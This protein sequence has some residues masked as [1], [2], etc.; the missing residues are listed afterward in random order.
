MHSSGTVG[1]GLAPVSASDNSE[2]FISHGKSKKNASALCQRLELSKEQTA[3]KTQRC[4]VA[5][6]EERTKLTTFITPWGAYHFKRNVLGL[7]A[8]RDEHILRRGDKALKGIENAVKVVEDVL[9]FDNDF[10]AH[11]RWA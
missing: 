8:A 2:S 1:K 6:D 7:K 11:V 4:Q 5:L 3:R 9:I 10:H